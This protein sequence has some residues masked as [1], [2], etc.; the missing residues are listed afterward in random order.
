MG[1]WI[2]I[3]AFIENGGHLGSTTAYMADI[4]NPLRRAKIIAISVN[5]LFSDSILIWRVYCVWG[6]N[7]K[8]AV[9]PVMLVLATAACT[10]GQTIEFSH[11]RS[12]H[13]M[14]S[15]S[16]ERWNISLYAMSVATNI[17]G[18]GLIV[19]GIWSMIRLSSFGT[20]M[21]TR[22]LAL[23]VESG[24]VYSLVMLVAIILYVKRNNSF[25]VV[26]E[27]LGQLS[28]IMPAMILS[29]VGL[30]LTA[31]DK[32]LTI[33]TSSKQGLVRQQHR[34]GMLSPVTLDAPILLVDKPRRAADLEK[35]E[36]SCLEGLSHSGHGKPVDHRYT[37]EFE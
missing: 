4:S 17:I 26:Y 1:L 36:P 33:S 21:Y 9:F 27:L 6:K 8:V 37:M 3:V 34:P 30:R 7:R 18:T 31:A 5:S 12:I 32:Q 15:G 16:L 25:F 19:F 35:S 13:D 22:L 23:V 20:A 29:L 2:I 28:S 24:M 14:Y 11:A 10:I